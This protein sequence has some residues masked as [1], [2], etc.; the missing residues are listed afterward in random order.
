MVIDKQIVGSADVSF[1]YFLKGDSLAWKCSNCSNKNELKLRI[2]QSGQLVEKLNQLLIEEL[3]K[4][5]IV[6]IR[7][8]NINIDSHLS[9]YVLWRMNAMFEVTKCENC[10]QEVI[11][12]FGMD[13]IQ[14]GREYVQFKGMWSL[15]VSNNGHN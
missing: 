5:N 10:S 1:D 13:E 11:S 6:N 12:I 2:Y 15:K 4:K 7:D 8:E 14:P 9:K 3:I